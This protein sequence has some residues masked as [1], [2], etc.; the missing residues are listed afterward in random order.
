MML[1]AQV[2]FF[3]NIFIPSGHPEDINP[4]GKTTNVNLLFIFTWIELGIDHYL[5]TSASKVIHSDP[6]KI[7]TGNHV[8]D[9]QDI[10]PAGRLNCKP[11]RWIGKEFGNGNKG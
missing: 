6:N 5:R 9:D 2:Y 1:P 8:P 3:R 10:G 4:T 7:M 11:N